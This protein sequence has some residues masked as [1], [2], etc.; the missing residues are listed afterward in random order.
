[1]FS[2]TCISYDLIPSTNLKKWNMKGCFNTVR[3]NQ[4]F[5]N[6][7]I[8]LYN[9][10]PG[11]F[12]YI[13]YLAPFSSNKPSLYVAADHQSFGINIYFFYVWKLARINRHLFLPWILFPFRK[14][15]S[16]FA[17]CLRFLVFLLKVIYVYISRSIYNVISRLQTTKK[18]EEVVSM[19]PSFQISRRN[20]ASSNFC[21]K[22]F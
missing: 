8:C 6:N 7:A 5:C 15:G 1:M 22:K 10:V 19:Q 17:H 14:Q 12:N 11:F 13:V 4:T 16:V 9:M 2:Y 3:N 18:V 20:L 21:V